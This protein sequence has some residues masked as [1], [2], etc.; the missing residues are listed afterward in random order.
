MK[1]RQ[2]QADE[3]DA[4]VGEL[5]AMADLPAGADPAALRRAREIRSLVRGQSDGRPA[6]EAPC[7]AAAAIA[8]LAKR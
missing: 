2:L 4:L 7:R 6:G 3:F 8:Y 5:R 1:L